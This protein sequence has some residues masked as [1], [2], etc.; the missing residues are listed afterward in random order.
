MSADRFLNQT[1]SWERDLSDSDDPNPGWDAVPYADPV[2][3]P[4]RK[5]ERFIE[6]VGPGGLERRQSNIIFVSENVSLGDKIDG[7]IVEGRSSGTRISG[8]TI[9]YRLVTE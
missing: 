9:L 2:T 4:A 5:E 3:I 1:V 7:E 8:D 6:V